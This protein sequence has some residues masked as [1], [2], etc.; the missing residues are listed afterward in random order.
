[1]YQVVYLGHIRVGFE[2]AAVKAWLAGELGISPM[3]AG[4]IIKKDRVII[5][6]GL[7][8]SEARALLQVYWDQGLVVEIE[9]LPQDESPPD[10]SLPAQTLP[11]EFRGKGGEYFRIWIVNLL[12]SIVTLGI[13]SA[14]AKVRRKSY[15]Y[16]NTRLDGEGFEYLADPKKILKGRLIAVAVLAIYQVALRFHPLA[17]LIAMLA[18]FAFYPWAVVKS[19][20]FNARNTAYRNIRFNFDGTYSQA[21][22]AFVGWPLLGALS[23]GL[24]APVAY[25]R[26]KKFI[27]DHLRYGTQPFTLTATNG[28][29]YK[30]FFFTSLVA[31]VGFSVYAI[32]RAAVEA[33]PG[34]VMDPN[35]APFRF[36]LLITTALVYLCIY[37]FFSALATNLLFNTSQAQG[38]G[39]KSTLPALGYAWV[40]LSNTIATALTLG[41]FHP[42]ASVRTQRYRLAHL[43][44]STTRGLDGFVAA[45]AEQVSALGSETSDL[46]GFD[47][48]L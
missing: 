9:A 1:M 6:K 45:Q 48:G 32:V 13:Y 47:F 27:V 20:A 37:A 16:G 29:Y 24:A 39:F 22:A 26:Q 43:S 28:N 8:E 34:S 2:K 15:F 14:W 17:G 11:F 36:I 41:F 19:L 35:P 18:L 46:L 4:Q 25:R 38:T 10:P 44:L 5:K 31:V 42:W 40:V 30:I 3:Q 21:L 7:A 23:L 33:V 12:L